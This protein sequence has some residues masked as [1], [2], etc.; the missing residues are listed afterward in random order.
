MA[1]IN[2]GFR[3]ELGPGSGPGAKSIGACVFRR[4]RRSLVYAIPPLTMN[5]RTLLH[6]TSAIG[7]T[8]ALSS[9]T[10]LRAADKAGKKLKVAVV[11]LGR[12]MA[13]VQALL[14]LPDVEIA[15]LAET[16]ANRLEKG[17]KVVADKQEVSCQ[18]VTDFRKILDDK[19][20]DAVFIA[21][22]NFWH[23]PMAILAMQAGKHV[24]VEKPGSQN[25]G[26]AEALVAAMKKYDRVVQ[27]GN[28]RRTWM[29]EA[30]QS[31]HGGAVGTVR[32]GRGFYYN[33]R[34]PVGAP[35]TPAPADMDWNLWQGPV[36][37]DAQ[38]DIKKYAHYDWH[39]LW[40]WGNGELGNNGIHTLDILRWGIKG[41]Y[42]L[43]VTYNGGRYFYDDIQETPD[44]GTAVYD[45]GHAG[46]SWECS[47]CHPR[48]AEK[49]ISDVVFYGD[50][51]TMA[52]A[53]DSWTIYDLKG[54]EIST[55]KAAGGG[56][57]AHMG[58]FLDAIRGTAQLNS[59]I[60][61]GQ[62]STM[63]CHLGNIAYRTNTVVR[64]DP[65]TG[66]LIDNPEGEKLWS[67]AYR[68]GW[69]L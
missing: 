64:C 7:I 53:R 23:T 14:R 33:S 31:L 3:A 8:A 57:P 39:W 22:P 2:R 18:G 36:P 44:T 32:Y 21:T 61:E 9:L 26:E 48:A 20:V 6:Q 66:K 51:G 25:P 47:S 49:P 68:P 58:N 29:K 59:P 43:K 38:H 45:F 52:M 69:G 41:D 10:R 16:D 27:M 54:K 60:D 37:D 13:H 15:Y 5:R 62:K 30:I 55:H 28:Q 17:L 63:L 40:H 50:N 19:S 34:K 4:A 35:V 67:R 56:D 1:V 12:G 24:Y 11:A 42:P 46:I 65:Q